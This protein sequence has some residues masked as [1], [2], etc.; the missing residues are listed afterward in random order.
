MKLTVSKYLNA[1]IGKPSTY[2]ECILYRAPGFVIDIDDIVAGTEI[3]GNGV[4]Y[5]SKDDGYFYWSGGISE[6]D[7]VFP[8]KEFSAFNDDEKIILL[9]SAKK[10]YSTLLKAKV[11]GFK[12]IGVGNKNNDQTAG[13]ALLVFVDA[14]VGVNQLGFVVPDSLVFKG[15]TVPVDVIAVGNPATTARIVYRNN[16]NLLLDKGSKIGMGGSI[17]YVDDNF[18]ADEYGSRTMIV[19][20][21]TPQKQYLMSCFHVLLPK[22]VNSNKDIYYNA[23]NVQCEVPSSKLNSHASQ[24][25]LTVFEG[26]YHG[27]YD[28]AVAEIA[29]INDYMN[30]VDGVKFTDYYKLNEIDSLQNKQVKI[31]GA[32]SYIQNATV[33]NPHCDI[34]ID[35]GGFAREYVG[36]ITTEKVILGG[37]SGGPVTDTAGKLIGY[38]VG[39]TIN[40]LFTYILPVYN[41]FSNHGYLLFKP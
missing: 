20:K 19:V 2:A 4:W 41:I 40:D 14:K 1:R 34:A 38:V 36:L 13:L 6:N 9:K 27:G 10:Y 23:N 7:L 15:V 28:Y 3:E 33:S 25:I 35:C 21:G 24:D 26:H 30:G 16:E 12:G 8:G 29:N 31:Y 17:S 11:T 39:A 5:H 32:T 37:D 22:M 18:H